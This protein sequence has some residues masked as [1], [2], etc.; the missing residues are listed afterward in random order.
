MVP[1]CSSA[2]IL[3]CAAAAFVKT[4]EVHVKLLPFTAA[5]TKAAA[6]QASRVEYALLLAM[7]FMTAFVHLTVA[8]NAAAGQR[9]LGF[10]R[11]A[12]ARVITSSSRLE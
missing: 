9:G 7:I 8:D 1:V 2:A 4:E 10:E 3:A 6:A 5:S 11:Y 12:I